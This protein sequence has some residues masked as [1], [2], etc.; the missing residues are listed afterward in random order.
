MLGSMPAPSLQ[1]KERTLFSEHINSLAQ[2]PACITVSVCVCGSFSGQAVR[3]TAVKCLPVQPYCLRSSL[4]H[5][6]DHTSHN[7][8]TRTPP[9]PPQT[10]TI[11]STSTP[12]CKVWLRLKQVSVW[13]LCKR[14]QALQRQSRMSMSQLVLK[15][16]GLSASFHL[17]HK[18]SCDSLR[19]SACVKIYPNYKGL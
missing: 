15:V 6:I 19:I 3:W 12:I 10:H 9:H 7:M 14:M 13:I 2:L 16:W 17:T 4:H 18:H 8:W 5:S 1:E 11:P